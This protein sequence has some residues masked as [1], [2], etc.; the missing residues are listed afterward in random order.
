MLDEKWLRTAYKNQGFQKKVTWAFNKRVH[1]KGIFVAD[2][3]L[4]EIRELVRDPR[5]K[6]SPKWTSPYILTKILSG[7]AAFL[8]DI[9]GQELNSPMNLDRLNKYYQ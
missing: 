2:L 4:K 5:G 3:V 8:T 7:G 6:F 1:S 9:Y